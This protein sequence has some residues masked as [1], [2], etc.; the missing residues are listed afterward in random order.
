[1]KRALLVGLVVAILAL[2]IP[3]F[4]ATS[5]LSGVITGNQGFVDNFDFNC[6]PYNNGLEYFYEVY[7]IN[8]TEAGTYTLTDLGPVK[9]YVGTYTLG[10][11]NPANPLANCINV[12]GDGGPF[13]FSS[14]GQYTLV[15]STFDAEVT[16]AFS[17][18][19]TGPGSISFV[20]NANACTQSLPAGSVVRSVP[21][22]APA[23]YDAD[24]GT[25]LTWNLPAGTWWI[26]ETSGDFAKVWIGCAANP[27]WIPLNAVAS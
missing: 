25:Q 24:L 18:T 27:I 26:S 12:D 9:P 23:F 6:Q 4:A 2:A 16:G 10:G 15:V 7:T 1:M 8:V 21:G 3:V 19:M 22:G 11:F 5:T 17:F 14:A 20:D 13:T